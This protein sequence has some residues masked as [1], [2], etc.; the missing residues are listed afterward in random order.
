MNAE[1]K[2]RMKRD[3][4]G[5]MRSSMI[6]SFFHRLI[7]VAAPTITAWM[8]GDMADHLLA[9]DIDGI[10]SNLA[11]FL[12]AVIFQVVVAL[13]FNLALNLA[14]TKQGFAYDGFLMQKFLKLPMHIVQTA[15][16]GSVME[17]LEE[18]SAAFCWNQM[19]MNSYPGAILIYLAV[20]IGVMIA[21][22]CHVVFCLVL[23]LLAALPTIRA[24]RIGKRQTQLKKQVSEYN[25]ARKQMEQELYDGR[26][27]ASNFAL[28]TYFI[29][30][31]N[32]LF[33]SFF[34]D[35]GKKQNKM[36]AKTEVLDFLCDYGVQLGV[37]VVGAILISFG[38]LTIGAML[39][40]FL[41]IPAVKAW[42]TYLSGYVT[43]RHDEKKYLSRLAFFYEDTE[44]DTVNDAEK[45]LT[46]IEA[47][48]VSFTYPGA[49]TATLVN[50]N[51][52]MDCNE[53]IR[54]VG[55]N[56]SGKT[57]L[58]S[59]L[60]GIYSVQSGEI[61][62]GASL[63]RI[64]NSVALQDQNGAIFS[65]T[66]WGNLF[67]PEGKREQAV[68][69]AQAFGLAKPMDYETL[70]D[71]DNLSPGERKKILLIR[72]LLRNA[73]FLFL[74]EPLNHLDEQGKAALVE[75][76]EKRSGGLLLISHQDFLPGDFP[77]REFRVTLNQ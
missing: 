38:K 48:D 4:K 46:R 61:N 6:A 68:A 51:F 12:C 21:N 71:G 66:V 60:S 63:S 41:M 28:G 2:K 30:R 31:L 69:M 5:F 34:S 10:K 20:F 73:P 39:G 59:A 45:Q 18:D 58:L 25:E 22:D 54:L 55:A 62:S 14:L 26:D 49:E 74:D 56:G 36:T 40:G 35:T 52:A 27:F 53:N 24:T 67:A 9:L 29:A 77:L 7:S 32:K 64:R 50:V 1:V 8:I 72:A 3:C 19:I 44:G 16:S 15:D 65:G 43:E 33:R 70:S 47:A 75:C 57:T 42:Y 11:P 17:R 76:L 37:V 23:F 13:L